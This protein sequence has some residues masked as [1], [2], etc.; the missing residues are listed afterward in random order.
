[1]LNE[2]NKPSITANHSLSSKLVWMNKSKSSKLVWMN[3]SKTSE[4]F[5]RRC[6]KQDKVTFN[7]RNIVNLFIV[8]ELDM[9]S[10]GLD[11]KF[12]LKHCLFRA[13]N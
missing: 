7:P 3:N 1:M 13:V 4:R 11:A 9:W 10:Q 12:T 5:I 6:L 2:K 8:Y